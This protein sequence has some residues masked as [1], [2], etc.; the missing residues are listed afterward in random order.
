MFPCVVRLSHLKPDSC[1]HDAEAWHLVR[2]VSRIRG[3]VCR[4]HRPDKIQRA[5]KA[6]VDAMADSTDGRPSAQQVAASVA[7]RDAFQSAMGDPVVANRCSAVL[8]ELI[9]TGCVSVDDVKR[10][11]RGPDDDR[12]AA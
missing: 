8:A 12:K 9:V 1:Q 10:L 4:S 11:L 5:A 3:L 2:G 6:W 7:A